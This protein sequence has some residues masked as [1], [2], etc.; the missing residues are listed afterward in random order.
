MHLLQ[1]RRILS[2]KEVFHHLHWSTNTAMSLIFSAD[3]PADAVASEVQA[4]ATENPSGPY[5]H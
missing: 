5:K 1:V 2:E 3:V 4:G